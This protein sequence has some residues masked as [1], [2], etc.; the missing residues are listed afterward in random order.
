MTQKNSNSATGVQTG[1]AN[2]GKK[3]PSLI[4]TCPYF[5]DYFQK[6]SIVQLQ[7]DEYASYIFQSLTPFLTQ[8]S[9][10]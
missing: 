9:R 5:T 6:A 7:T 2:G 4:T 1:K 8:T 3:V 10:R